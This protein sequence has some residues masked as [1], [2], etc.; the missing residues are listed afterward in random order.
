MMAMVHNSKAFAVNVLHS[1]SRIETVEK[2]VPDMVNL[3]TSWDKPFFGTWG[4]V[5]RSTGT[6]ELIEFA[7]VLMNIVEV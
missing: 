2:A 4:L 7:P 1:A 6:P 3:S 5:C